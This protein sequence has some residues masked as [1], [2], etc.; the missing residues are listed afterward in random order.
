L[1]LDVTDAAQ[2]QDVADSI[3]S[4]DVLVNNAG[5]GAYETELDEA[6]VRAHLGVNLIGPL[7]LTQALL[8]QLTAAPGVVV[9]VSS[10]AAL[11]A[12]PVMPAYS[13]SKAAALSMTQS[14]RALLAGAGIRVH[15]VLA[16]PIDTDM[17]RDLPIEKAA[18]ADVARAI[19]DGVDLGHE[20]IFPDAL[21]AS[22]AEGW[23]GGL[24][25]MLELQNAGYVN[26]A[27]A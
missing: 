9:N 27:V 23:R 3:P 18:P 2:I 15:A 17:S 8:A 11:A 25:K 4:L 22:L 26:G 10:I 19:F 21:S 7:N 5:L 13:I 14:Q 12:L 1:A 6:S 20:E 16:G 24:A